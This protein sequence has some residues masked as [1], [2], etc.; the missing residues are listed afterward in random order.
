[1]R[2][3]ILLILLIVSRAHAET[4]GGVPFN[5]RIATAVWTEALT[6]MAPRTLEAVPI[7]QMTVWG[8]RGLTALD[9]A[10]LTTQTDGRLRL[11]TQTRTLYEAAAPQDESAVAWANTAS[12]MAVAA[13]NVSAAVRRAGTEGIVQSFFD[14]LFNHLDPYSR[15]VPPE[16]AGDDRARRSGRAGLGLT[17][18]Q[19]GRAVVVRAVIRESPA[20]IAGLRVG[21]TITGVDRKSVRGLDVRTISALLDGPQ[22]T[23][24]VVSWR[25]RDG[26]ARDAELVR[27]M[28]PPETVFSERTANVLTLRIT[29]FSRTTDSHLAEALNEGL[30]GP[31]PAT[32]IIL[33]LRGNRGGLLRQAVSTADILLPPGVVAITAGRAP[34]ANYIWRST[35]GQ[36]G[37]DVPVVVI[38]DGRTAS[39]AEI[40]AAALADRGRAVV[41]GSSTLGKGLVQTIDPLPDGGELFVTWSRVLAPLG[42]PIQG[43]GVLPQVCTS[44]GADFLRRTMEALADGIQPMEQELVAQRLARAPL[45][46]ARVVAL[47][48]AC[49]AAEGRDQDMGTARALLADPVAYSAALM[50]PLV[51]AN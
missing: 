39:A 12:V 28:V 27:E 31:R 36:L 43:L 25:S 32:G 23:A 11:G 19:Q 3:G 15:Y 40:L 5:P 14:E 51:D 24:V 2:V 44:R 13:I 22:E 42:W 20:A 7:S 6:F 35:A 33:D 49:P 46:S 50:P 45:P 10:L 47:R 34:E 30:T 37:A 26:R 9:P 17:L 38:V 41:I 48:S 29:G 4:P 21:D 18:G 1:M 16:E 8:L